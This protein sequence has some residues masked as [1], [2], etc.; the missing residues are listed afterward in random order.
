MRTVNVATLKARLSE[1]LRIAQGGETIQILDRR[2]PVAT[3]SGVRVTDGVRR[4]NIL[5]EQGRAVWGGGKPV[6]RPLRPR[7]G[8]ARIA[9][10]V[11]EDRG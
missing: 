11:L 4:A 6:F 5:V 1:Y 3:L 10:A 7:K 2:K 8:P 9:E